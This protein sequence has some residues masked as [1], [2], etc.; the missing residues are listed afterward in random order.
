[1]LSFPAGLE[2]PAQA[3]LPNTHPNAKPTPPMRPAPPPPLTTIDGNGNLTRSY[4]KATAHQFRPTN[5]TGG[6]QGTQDPQSTTAQG[7]SQN[8]TKKPRYPPI[9]IEKIM[10]WATHL[11]TLKEKLGR[12]INARPFG[13]GIRIIPTDDTEFRLVQSYLADLEKETPANISW[14]CYSPPESRPL[15]VAIRGIPVKTSLEEIAEDLRN[16]GVEVRYLRQIKARQG[17]P[18]C[19]YFAEKERSEEARHRVYDITEILCMLGIRVENWRGKRGVRQCHR[20]QGFRHS[21]HNCH[22]QIACVRCGGA[23]SA[24]DCERPITQPPTCANCNGTHTAN[25]PTCAT[26]RKEARNKR[27]GTVAVTGENKRPP[28]AQQ[29]TVEDNAGPSLMAPANG[30]TPRDKAPSK[31]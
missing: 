19:I 9:V 3:P 21:S 22:R 14:F 17:R 4:A 24:K 26:L 8:S 11:R 18:G 28:N 1:M 25:S 23:H 30:P 15:K 20:C 6:A 13:K 2:I 16:K 7:Q 27:T 10:A 31:K 5:Q 29:K 12:P